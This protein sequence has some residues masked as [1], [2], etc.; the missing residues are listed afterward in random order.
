MKRVDALSWKGDPAALF[1]PR[2]GLRDAPGREAVRAII[3][4]APDHAYA[5]P[6]MSREST[7]RLAACRDP[8]SHCS[9]TLAS[10]RLARY[11]TPVNGRRVMTM[12][13]GVVTQIDPD[14]NPPL[15]F[16][17]IIFVVLN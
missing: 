11:A 10:L 9:V 15:H 14:W 7:D 13:A 12:F 16:F 5:M 6:S 2:H 4:H 3:R 8:A 17:I 1:S